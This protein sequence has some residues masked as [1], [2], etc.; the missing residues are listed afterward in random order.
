M[1]AFNVGWRLRF[2]LAAPEHTPITQR[3]GCQSLEEKTVVHNRHV[4]RV[5]Y[6]VF[7]ESR[8]RKTDRAVS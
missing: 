4:I 2:N 6:G 7:I 8:C 3:S 5:N 1:D